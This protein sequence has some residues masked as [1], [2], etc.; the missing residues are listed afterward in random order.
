M[1]QNNNKTWAGY[2]LDQLA[3]ERAVTIARIEIEKQR[4]GS[5]LARARK[6]NLFLTK[7]TFSRM[8]S[9]VNFTDMI[10][11]GVRIWRSLSPIFSKRK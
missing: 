2:S 9:I 1:P 7:S 6:G 11:V 4:L 10:V 3:Y 8:L 5:E